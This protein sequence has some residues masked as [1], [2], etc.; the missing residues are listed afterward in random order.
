MGATAQP[1]KNQ[2]S[3]QQSLE[4]VSTIAKD[5]TLIETT[6][7][8]ERQPPL[9]FEEWK[10]G[11]PIGAPV[12]KIPCKDGTDLVPPSDKGRLISMGVVLLPS[13]AADYGTQA[14]LLADIIAFIH[15]YADVPPFEEELIAHYVLMT[16][17]FD[18]FTAVPYLRFLGE[19]GS[20]KSRLLQI[21]GNLAYKAIVGGGSTSTSSLFRL[22]GVYRGT[23]ILDEADYEHSEL[24]SDIIK[25]LNQGYMSRL[26]VLRSSKSGDDYEPRAFDVFGPKILTTRLQF[27][28][29]ALETRCLTLRTG[30][31]KVRPEVPRQ[32]PPEFHAEA[33]ALRNRLLR[34]RFEN[35]RRIQTD[36]SKLLDLEPR[37]TQIG[38][39]LYA[40]SDD[41]GFRA[42]LL[43]FLRHQADEQHAERP[44]T[45]VAEAIRQ[46]LV[47]E[48]KWPATLTVK[49]VADKAAEVSIDWETEAAPSFTAKRTGPLVRSMGFETRRTATGYQFFVTKTKLA[50]LATRYRL[51]AGQ[52]GQA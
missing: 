11:R 27:K 2:N 26:P 23:F 13:H 42:D 37:L 6:Y 43:K 33:L 50:E 3:R 36:E 29:Q 46:L 32:L 49:N 20:G 24:W 15:R 14:E 10:E 31:G 12:E 22:L 5:G 9:Q 34:W 1:P 21:A 41:A 8:P 16:W 18:R 30:D 40:V 45:I 25:I 47:N 7:D 17:V 19:P 35:F 28:D 52:G 44:L 4:T 38:T 39:P 51:G 48:W